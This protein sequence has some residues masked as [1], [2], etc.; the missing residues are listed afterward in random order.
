MSI[1]IN[2]APQKT[3]HLGRST[4]MK[5]FI[6]PAYGEAV[7]P[8]DVPEPVLGDQDVLVRVQAAGLNQLDEKIRAGEFKQFLPYSLPLVLGHDVAG[9]VIRV[10]ANVR[11]F[12][13]GDE[14][15]GR[16]GDGHIGTFAER[17]AVP[18][19]ELALKPRN[20]TMEEAASLPLVALT[21]WQ[22]LVERA[23][24]TPGQKVL[25]HAGAGGFGSIAVQLAAFLGARVATTVSVANADFARDLG[26]ERVID[27]RTEA[28]DEVLEGY[29]VVVDSLGAESVATSLRV[30]APGGVVVG[31]SGPP[32]P[33][34]AEEAGVGP[35][36]RLGIA[37]L[38]RGVRRQAK[39]LGV[40]YEFLLM[41]A[42]GE[43]LREITALVEDGIL[44]PVIGRVFPFERSVEA[45]DALSAGG[46]RG[47]V[48]ISVP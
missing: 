17:I 27:Y 38:S 1:L 13:P 41:R 11:S 2:E 30:L 10:G 40:R 39:R 47:K 35:L 28:V 22:V 33:S 48:V 20:L 4:A 9:T 6:V 15:Y 45:F 34:F 8:A 19:G 43:Q 42:S 36:V 44:R 23:R 12:H 16:V 21:A 24:V 3:A 37:A 25:V 46:L 5:A 29:D 7:E 18:E 32:T 26:A 14:V 31:I